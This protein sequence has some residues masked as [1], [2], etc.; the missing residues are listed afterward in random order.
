MQRLKSVGDLTMATS[1][2]SPIAQLWF[3]RLRQVISGEV[4][5]G[6]KKNSSQH[7]PCKQASTCFHHKPAVNIT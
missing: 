5:V 4:H 1:I 7:L 6:E 3:W 2:Y